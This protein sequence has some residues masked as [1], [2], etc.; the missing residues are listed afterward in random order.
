[1]RWWFALVK[2][3]RESKMAGMAKYAFVDVQNT[4]TTTKRLLGFQIDW[5]KF[6]AF[7][8]DEWKCDRERRIR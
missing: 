8:K 2:A 7:L 3:Y 6:C 5:Q 4:D 1:V